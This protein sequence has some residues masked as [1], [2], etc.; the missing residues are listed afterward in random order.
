MAA[1]VVSRFYSLFLM[2]SA[3]GIF[4]GSCALS[5]EIPLQGSMK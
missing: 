3:V 5:G 1:Q 4:M 2:V